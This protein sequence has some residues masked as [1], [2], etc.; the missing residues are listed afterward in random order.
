M[1]CSIITRS[2]QLQLQM[3]CLVGLQKKLL[4]LHV[5]EF[6]AFEPHISKS[7]LYIC[8]PRFTFLSLTFSKLALSSLSLSFNLLSLI[9]LT[10]YTFL[11]PPN[12]CL[13]NI[14]FVLATLVVK[15]ILKQSS[16][17]IY[18]GNI[19]DMKLG[20]RAIGGKQSEPNYKNW[21]FWI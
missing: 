11:T 17:R 5:F 21:A 9:L 12:L 3:F 15:C 7:C 14:C 13:R 20:C 8:K 19:S 18:K 4:D 1:L 16:Q 10:L 2:K 6:C